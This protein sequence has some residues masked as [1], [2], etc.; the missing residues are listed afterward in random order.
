[1]GESDHRNWLSVKKKK[2]ENLEPGLWFLTFLRLFFL[3]A[4]APL[5]AYL[6]FPPLSNT[7]LHTHIYTTHIKIVYIGLPLLN[8][9]CKTSPPTFSLPPFPQL[10]CYFSLPTS[11]PLP[12][13][14]AL[15]P[16]IALFSLSHLL[17]HSHACCVVVRGGV[18]TWHWVCTARLSTSAGGPVGFS[19]VWVGVCCLWSEVLQNTFRIQTWSLLLREG[20]RQERRGGGGQGFNTTSSS[21]NATLPPPGPCFLFLS[22]IPT[23]PSLFPSLPMP[24]CIHKVHRPRVV[25]RPW[26]KT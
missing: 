18:L 5:H 17:Y 15:P 12:F 21:L 8:T 23:S 1:M 26:A 14:P 13:Q 4:S 22:L 10:S 7:P 20:W 16:P 9:I 3:L 11:F 6:P 2:K 25:Q 24:Q 19:R